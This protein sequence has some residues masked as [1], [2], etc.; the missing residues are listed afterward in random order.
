MERWLHGGEV[1]A[2]TATPLSRLPPL[3]AVVAAVCRGMG[4]AAARQGRALPAA[5]VTRV[6]RQ[7]AAVAAQLQ[8]AA[9]HPT[10]RVVMAG[11]ACR[12]A[13]SARLHTAV[14]VAAAPG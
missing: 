2:T 10:P 12:T 8:L 3:A 7:E 14:A 5:P 11:Q 1:A 4:R 9:P 13:C 6:R